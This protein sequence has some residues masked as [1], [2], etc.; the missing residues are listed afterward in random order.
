MNEASVLRFGSCIAII[1][2]MKNY[3]LPVIIEQDTNGY[4][5]FCPDLQGC[6]SQGDT[7]DEVLANIKDA[8]TLHIQDHLAESEELP[9]T[10]SVSLSTIHITL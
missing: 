3:N 4:F 2:T 9:E 1:T 7:Y 6:Y 5:A 8:I 10:K